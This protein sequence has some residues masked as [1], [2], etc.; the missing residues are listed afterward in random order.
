MTNTTS[1]LPFW[2]E[3]AL[4]TPSESG[5]VHVAGANIAYEVW[6]PVG[7]P[8]V[9]L[10]HGSNAHLEWWRFTAPFLADNF[11]VAALDLS[12]NGDSDWRER[13][14]G[15]LF[16]DEVWAVCQ[17]ARLGPRPFVVGHSFGGFVALET[18]HHHAPTL[19]G[20][21]SWTSRSRHREQYLEWGMR[22]DATESNRGASCAY[23]KTKT[24]HW[25]ASGCCPTSPVCIRQCYGTWLSMR[26]RRSRAAGP[27]NSIRHCST[28]WRWA[29]TSATSS[30]HCTCR[31]ALILGEN[32]EDEGAF[33][34]HH[35]L[36]ITG[37]YLPVHH[38]AGHLSPS[39]VRRPHGC[40]HGHQAA[41]A[42]MAPTGSC[43]R[44]QTRCNVRTAPNQH[45][46]RH[47]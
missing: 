15:E 3:R 26:S 1:D 8:G 16:A 23:T 32:S 22:A 41:F 25:A 30:R 10:V 20:I 35:M 40:G 13:Y 4:D 28:I 39:D 36:E 6:G 29:S 43:G 5:N 46:E 34:A 45:G 37:G 44:R 38:A 7:K 9:A 14:H 11:R 31:S 24:R 33:F 2:F 18:G 12:G 19:G 27:G 42:R 47:D 21:C 17:A